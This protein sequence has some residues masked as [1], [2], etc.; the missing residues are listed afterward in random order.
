M[1]LVFGQGKSGFGVLQDKFEFPFDGIL[2]KGNRNAP[3]ALG[4]RHAPIE[5]GAV[6]ADDGQYV[7]SFESQ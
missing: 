3:Q 7:T 1:L 6:V 4:S 5:L 2:V